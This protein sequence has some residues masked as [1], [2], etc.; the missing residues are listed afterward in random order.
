MASDKQTN[1]PLWEAQVHEDQFVDAENQYET[2]QQSVSMGV[3]KRRALVSI[4]NILNQSAVVTPEIVKSTRPSPPV[5]SQPVMLEAGERRGHKRPAESVVIA[6]TERSR[7]RLR[8][9]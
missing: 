9:L 5:S 1:S 4:E 7:K 8:R 2:H 6:G 3:K